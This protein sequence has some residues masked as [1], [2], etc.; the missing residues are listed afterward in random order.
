MYVIV[1][2]AG[3]SQRFKNKGIRISKPF[4]RFSWK[5]SDKKRM[6]DYAIMGAASSLSSHLIIGMKLEDCIQYRE[7]YPNSICVSIL[8]STGQADTLLQ[9]LRSVNIKNSPILVLNSDQ[10]FTYPLA[11]FVKQSES[12]DVALLTFDTKRNPAYSYVDAYPEFTQAVEKQPISD[13][14]IAGAFYFKD[15]SCL[16][17]ALQQ[18]KADSANSN[19]EPYLSEA[20]NYITGRKLAV[21]IPSEMVIG[22][23]TPEEL[24]ADENV[25]QL[26]W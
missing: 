1:P 18:Q 9:I 25:T 5:D 14:A 19:K 2:A 7:Q 11:T 15:A 4:I 23:G 8:S 3:E 13:W 22:W 17:T 20:I 24:L 12:F 6:I 16:L 21:N 10:M 26:E